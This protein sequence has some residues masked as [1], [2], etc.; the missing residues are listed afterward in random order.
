[1]QTIR[2]KKV[3]LHKTELSCLSFLSLLPINLL[4]AFNKP[5]YPSLCFRCRYL[6][7]V[8]KLARKLYPVATITKFLLSCSFFFQM[9]RK[10]TRTILHIPLVFLEPDPFT[11][12]QSKSR[13][14]TTDGVHVR[15]FFVS[16][17][18]IFSVSAYD[19]EA[20]S[21]RCCIICTCMLFVYVIAS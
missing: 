3:Q 9:K 18:I 14:H 10:L 13:E 19:S 11:Y 7:S 16:I 1:M 2:I 8:C 12:I 5:N 6:T 17:I 21:A 4:T 20:F 15:L